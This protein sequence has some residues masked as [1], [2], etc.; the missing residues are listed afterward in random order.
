M[1][2]SLYSK[3]TWNEKAVRVG[4]KSGCGAMILQSSKCSAD[5]ALTVIRG[6]WL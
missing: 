5:D 1:M 3:S 6:Y 4:N 2:L